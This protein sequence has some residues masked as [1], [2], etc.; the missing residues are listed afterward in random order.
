[1]NEEENQYIEELERVAQKVYKEDY[2]SLCDDR[3]LIVKKLQKSGF[4]EEEN[5]NNRKNK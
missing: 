1:M 2:H 4:L 3:K 5:E